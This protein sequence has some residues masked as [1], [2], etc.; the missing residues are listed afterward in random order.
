MD[1]WVDKELGYSKFK[2]ERLRKRFLTIVKSVDSCGQKTIPEISKSWADTKGMYRFLSNDRVDESEILAS[3]FEM[4][5]QRIKAEKSA[6]LILHDT[7]EFTYKR[8]NPED[9]GFT[10]QSHAPITA[11]KKFPTKYTVCG[12]LMHSSLA[13]TSNGTPLGLTSNRFWSRR[14]FKNTEQMK[15]HINP[16][17]VPIDQKESIRWLQNMEQSHSPLND[18]S[19][20]IHIA[21]REGDIYEYFCRCEEIG[22]YF[23]SRSCVNRLAEQSTIVEEV[24]QN[25][26]SFQHDIAFTNEKG[27]LI[28]ARLTVK[29]TKLEVHPPIG[30]E[31]GY[32]D[33]ELVVVSATEEIAPKNRKPICWVFITNLP[34]KRNQDAIKTL[35]WYK[36]RWKIETYF[37]VIK[38]GFRA[39]ESKLRDRKSVV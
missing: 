15:R 21:D 31:K 35:E 6:V 27:K 34:V 32:P 30:K 19:I 25:N 29:H 28:E 20:Y 22:A 10:R 8:K 3:H 13:V 26:S 24:A 7:C 2:D 37:K 12:I 14:T 23:I 11:K 16:T 38:S 4:T 1:T 33:L 9:I 39:E 5:Q 36:Q 17:R 18:P